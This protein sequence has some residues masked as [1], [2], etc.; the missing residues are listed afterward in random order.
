MPGKIH[1]LLNHIYKDVVANPDLG[2]FGVLQILGSKDNFLPNTNDRLT[3]L[4]VSDGECVTWQASAINSA[5]KDILNMRNGIIE[6]KRASIVRGYRMLIEEFEV[7]ED[8][9]ED[10]IVLNESLEFL[11][12]SFYPEVF[13]N[14]GMLNNQGQKVPNHPGFELTPIRMTR[15]KARLLTKPVIKKL[16]IGGLQCGKCEKK[17]KTERGFINHKCV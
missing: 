6:I 4:K 11:D 15:S 9:F 3:L 1:V 17:Y 5:L 13:K 10:E 14:K 16:K 2:I 7:I 12:K 8:T